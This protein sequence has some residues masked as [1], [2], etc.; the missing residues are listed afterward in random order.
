MERTP[1]KA[2]PPRRS[3]AAA[4]RGRRSPR[5]P[6]PPEAPARAQFPIV[7]IGASAGGLDPFKRLFAAMPA[8]T[9]AGFVLVPHLDPRHESL[10]VDLLS[11]CTSMP[12]REVVDGIEM[13]PNHVYVI[14]PGA[15][16]TITARTLHLTRPP[17][18]AART[19]IDGFLQ[20]L[21]A[22]QQARAIGIIL[23]G[24]GSHG[25]RGLTAIHAAGGL[26]LAQSPESAEHDQMPRAAIATGLVH[27]VLAPEAMPA[28][29]VRYGA[30]PAASAADTVAV[31][32]DPIL[33]LLRTQAR[34]DFRG[35]RRNMVLRRIRRRMDLLGLQQGA[36]Y[37]EHLRANPPEVEAL[38]ND[39]SIGVTSFFREPEAFQVL[40]QVV[41]PELVRRHTANG[42]HAPVRV[43]VAGCASGEEAYSIAILF[44]EQFAAAG[45]PAHLQIFATDIDLEAIDI[46]RAGVY[47]ASIAANVSPARLQRFFVKSG[48]HHYQVSKDVRKVITFAPQHLLSDAPFSRLDLISCRNVLIY[49]EPPVQA[50]VLTLFQFAL[51]ER[52]YL[53]LGPAESAGAANGRF[54]TVSKKWRV[55][56]KAAD[57]ARPLAPIPI[58]PAQP[59]GT[60]T[61]PHTDRPR[62]AAAMTDL[63]HRSLL[64][65]FAPAALLV[66]ARN[67]ILSVQGPVGDYLEFPPGE[68]T[69]DLLT[70][71][72]A[73]LRAAIRT[74]CTEARR[75]PKGPALAMARVKRQRAYVPCTISASHVGGTTDPE[76]LLVV[77]FQDRPVR[78]AGRSAA[79]VTGTSRGEARLVHALEQELQATRA[80]LQ[81]TIDE[82]QTANEELRASHEEVMSMN[83]ELQSTNE[84]MET[85]K[86]EL[87]SL[88]EELSTVNSQLQDK[89][90][91]LDAA[92][93]DMFNLLASTDIATVFLDRDLRIKRYTPPTV[94]LLSLLATDI[95][96]PFR[97]IAPRVADATL[98]DD[99]R[100]V[101]TMLAPVDAV[102]RADDSEAYLRRVVPY[103]T[104]D[105]RIDGVVITWV[106]ITRRLAAEAESRRFTAVLRDSN[107]A[108]ALL[109]LDGRIVGWNRGA[110]R[111][112][113][114][115]EAE[116]R[117]LSLPDLA[118]EPLRP[119]TLA[120]LA[121]IASGAA[122]S[123]SLETQRVT[124]DGR[125][126]DVWLTMTLLRDG[127]GHPN[128]LVTTERDVTDLKEGVAATQAADLYGRIIEHLPAGAVLRRDGTI[129]LNRAAE[130]I[131][132]Y[133]RTDLTSAEAWWSTLH[134][135]DGTDARRLYDPPRTEPPPPAPAIV[136]ITRKDG[137]RR[138]V[139]LTVCTLDDRHELWMLVDVTEAGR[140]LDS[141]R[142][143]E[144]FL[145]AIVTT[146][147]DAIITIDRTG[148]VE[149][150]NPA[151]ERTFGYPAAEV[152]GQSL[153]MLMAS[154]YRDEHDSYI[155]H[156][157]K[158]G[159]ARVIGIGRE[160][161]GR[162]KD[163]TAVPLDLAVSEIDHRRGFTGVMRDLSE[164]RALEWRLAESQAEERR[165][166]AREL[167]DEVGGHMT[168]I[169]LLAQALHAALEGAQSPA[170][171]RT[172][173]LV[174]SIDEAH[175][176]LRA[177]IH[178]VMPVDAI[179]EGLM[180][181]LR[182]LTRQCEAVSGVAC[183][184]ECDP[185]VHVDDPGTALHLYRIAQEALNNAVRHAS[186]SAITMSLQRE[187]EHIGIAVHD[188]GHGLVETVAGHHGI[189]IA[190][191]LQRARLL[192][193]D[194][195]VRTRDGGGTSVRCWVPAMSASVRARP[196][197]APV[198]PPPESA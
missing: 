89:V 169:A 61:A 197:V 50:K 172:R 196:P 181:A 22:D 49:L 24:T 141:L 114:Y 147:A 104:A 100:R 165:H 14:P 83:E 124:R 72:R 151:A 63:L 182:K 87:Q 27:E 111:L 86:E 129:A 48:P 188:D 42:S 109:D 177:I 142:R 90:H 195:T 166:M 78:R 170:T 97:D 40:E 2:R 118:P 139:E 157:V 134:R 190:S 162:R 73:G 30:R 33:S 176:R 99:C 31:D 18:S 123:E 120:L 58:L 28:A 94:R 154:P 130:R 192:G 161:V 105:E 29:I 185:A 138:H 156:Y 146:A 21:A 178:G 67:E 164:R 96:R 19:A 79:T 25:A 65:A 32:L 9:G 126:R 46:A 91:E 149:T 15:H 110:E 112:Y 135:A 16:L 74:A 153:K 34:R 88:N 194:C 7:G 184:F 12:V 47:P 101:I 44:L 187:G 84:E 23:S 6:A 71:A 113:G 92:N 56:A 102:V 69:R 167:H 128:A 160:V 98:I 119:T 38:A 4:T 171:A 158:T 183:H 116:A 191:M 144:D 103:R 43:W 13:Q 35:Y 81:G 64:Q 152:V 53:M 54:T 140:A 26:V 75:A 108:V 59:R 76:G 8:D 175:R 70:M 150:F 95:G 10:M 127:A 155:Q 137:E 148:V 131:T 20:A 125:T 107:D 52:G 179:P 174:K 145:R 68:L 62:P 198:T 93:N 41:V 180:A 60:S 1:A 55:F 186:A 3:S 17:R 82:L 163:G 115:T 85:S 121:R 117:R 77:T 51:A 143:S 189:G 36:A 37:V 80:D 57:D 11:K 159:E 66:N 5:P 132:G 133:A 136:A 193:G 106:D 39:L 45:Q 122:A 173:D 168:G